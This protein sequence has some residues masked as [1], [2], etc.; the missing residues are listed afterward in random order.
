M[1]GV[2]APFS[3]LARSQYRALASMRWSMFRNGLRTRH[4]AIELGARTIAFAFYTLMGLGMAA[5]FGGGAY[6]IVA[7]EKW[8][9]LPALF[10]ALFVLWQVVPVTLASFQEH[11]DLGGLLRFPVSFGAF[12][13]LHLIFG[14]VDA[15]TMM[16]G[17]CCL[18]IWIG[19]I[20]AR[21]DLYASTAL[22]VFL[23][24]AFNIF[25]VRA[26]SAW[27]DRWLAQR[28]TREI[29]GAL[30]AS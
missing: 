11:F 26:I 20:V 18:G 30:S 5:G 7:S 29:V 17:L 21:S 3:A 2:A 12:F 9:I 28:R 19:I 1:A 10:W 15:S 8:E 4:G 6:A 14:L 25:L 24:A 13:L 16:G 23:Y 22:V 27:I